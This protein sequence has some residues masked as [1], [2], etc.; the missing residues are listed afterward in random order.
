MIDTDAL[1]PDAADVL[2]IVTAAK[3]VLRANLTRRLRVW[4]EAAEGS[5][6]KSDVTQCS[7]GAGLG[8]GSWSAGRSG[9]WC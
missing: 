3:P 9:G 6:E 1:S 8:G 2:R 7:D 5:V 4:H